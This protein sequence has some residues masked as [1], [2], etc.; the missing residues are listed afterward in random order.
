MIDWSVKHGVEAPIGVD[1]R[2]NEEQ[3]E[4][5]R[6][7]RRFAEEVIRPVAAQYG[8]GDRRFGHA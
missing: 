1:F 5:R 8:G 2:L 6:T 4:F 7:C 3:V